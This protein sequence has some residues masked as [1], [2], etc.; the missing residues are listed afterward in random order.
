[1]ARARFVDGLLNAALVGV[2]LLVAVLLYGLVSRT[3][4]PS[5]TPTRDAAPVLGVEPGSDPIQVEVRN[6]SG[7]SG[8]ARETTAYLRRRGFDV[9]EV[10]NAPAR[11]ASAVVVR[12]GT[13]TYAERVGAALGIESVET[14]PDPTD[15]DPDVAVH[16]GADYAGLTPFREAAPDEPPEAS[17]DA[18][19]ND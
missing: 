7:V 5:T 2:G 13:R 14:G 3:F 8:L 19:P 9:V 17:G 16:I 4:S 10:G 6:A 11:E 1:M 12:A 18:A 15:Y